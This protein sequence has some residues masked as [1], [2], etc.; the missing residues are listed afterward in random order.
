MTM[1]TPRGAARACIALAAFLSVSACATKGD[2]R[3]VSNDIRALSARQD[4]I[5]AELRYQSSVTQDTLRTTVRDL[6]QIRGELVRRLTDIQ[7]DLD[8]LTEL[9]GENQRGIAS[10][11]D[12]M[13][14][15][16]R[17]GTPAGGGGFNLSEGGLSDGGGAADDLY[18]AAVAQFDRGALQTARAAFGDFLVQ[19]PN[20]ELAPRAHYYLAEIL[21]REDR[22]QDAIREF[23]VI[24]E[25]FPLDEK[26]PDALYR[27]G[28][29]H[30]DGG[31]LD[32]ARRYLELVIN[33]YPDN[34]VTPLAREALRDLGGLD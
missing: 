25:R 4:S 9:T 8:R 19:Y 24:R 28:L 13:D 2:L 11:R 18:A 1:P 23:L 3:T 14:A 20:D 27:V 31:D 30:R 22:P 16:R 32:E 10:L 15:A 29:L 6:F 7:E 33:T 17:G 34:P 5:L 21:I 26:V 12:Q